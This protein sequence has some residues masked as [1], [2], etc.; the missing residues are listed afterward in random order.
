MQKGLWFSYFC[1]VLEQFKAYIARFD[2]CTPQDRILLAVSGGVD[3]MTMLH[4]FVEAGYQCTLAHCNFQLR[5]EESDTDEAFVIQQ[6]EQYGLPVYINKCEAHQKVTTEGISVEMAARSLR[7]RWFDKLIKTGNFDKVAIGHNRNDDEETFFIKLFRGSGLAGLKGIPL[8]RDYIIRPLMF[9]TRDE[10]LT[11][12]HEKHLLFREDST[13]ATDLYLRNRI[14]HHLLPYLE[15]EFPGSR[16]SLDNSLE[17]LKEEEDL[18]ND[19]V[20]EIRARYFQSESDGFSIEKKKIA[21]I[22]PG[23]FYYLLEPFGFNR[24][25]TDNILI[26]A[27]TEQPGQLFHADQYSL[28]CDRD[29]LLVQQTEPSNPEIF[30]VDPEKEI[31]RDPLQLKMETL[32]NHPGFV[33]EEDPDIAYFDADKLRLPLTLRHWKKGDTFV[34]FG[35]KGKKRLSDFFIDEKVNRFE[36]NKLWLLLSGTTILWI[37]GL[38]S[39]EK[40]RVQPKTKKV[41]KITHIRN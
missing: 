17:K 3:S 16:Q 35:M 23:L 20:S 32:D 37:V 38:R 27:K 8:Q 14:R 33:F 19:Y 13:N 1:P 7:Y 30:H 25:M 34:P 5:K 4:L 2:L 41:L 28:L 18:L 29:Q 21:N 26:A 10:I 36:K 12:A 31:L 6:A 24:N 22:K 39:S 15:K 40:F 9:A 11:Y